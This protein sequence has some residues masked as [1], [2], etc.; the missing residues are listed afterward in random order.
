MGPA[1]V[2]PAT[3]LILAADWGDRRRWFEF[4]TS[5]AECRPIVA[6]SNGA[7]VGTG[8][9]SANGAV[10]WIG[11]IFVA[12]DLRGRG[13]GRALTAAVIDGLESAGCRT[14]V[15]VSTAEGLPLYER[16]GFAIQT[17]YRIL[18][19]P[20]LHGAAVDPGIRRFRDADLPAIT[21]LDT[22]ATGEDRAHVLGRFANS[23]STRILASPDD[24]PVGFVTRAPWG[25]GATVARD[26]GSAMRIL[27]ARR[28]AAGPGGRVRVG[29]VDENAE[30]LA[31]LAEAGLT[32]IWSAPRL[33]RGEPIRWRPEWIWGQLN[34]AIG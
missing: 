6:E 32:P 8:V 20:G 28:I 12:P 3:D 29:L 19:A 10:G 33:I 23:D 11:T 16:M 22:E 17:H 2:D 21:A 14:F 15:L 4:A 25:G 27:T 31:V 26:A 30:G 9:G 34:H 13:L 1:D 7:I 24:T 5:Q 18:E